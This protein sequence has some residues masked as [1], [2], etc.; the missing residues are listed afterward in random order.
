MMARLGDGKDSKRR[1]RGHGSIALE[2]SLLAGKTASDAPK[3]T[4]QRRKPVLYQRL[5]FDFAELAGS[6]IFGTRRGI[7]S[8][9]RHT[10]SC[11]FSI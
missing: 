2:F 7:G 10:V 9:S 1:T 6:G 4:F 8:G 5:G 3:S 11:L